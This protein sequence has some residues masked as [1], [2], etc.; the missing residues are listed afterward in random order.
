MKRF[1]IT[2][3]CIWLSAI[4]LHAQELY[5][6]PN[7][8]DE[9][10][11]IAPEDLGWCED[12]VNELLA[13]LEANNTKAFLI[14]KDGKIVVESYMNNFSQ[15]ENWY[16]ASAGKG[17]TAFL[18]GLAQEE[19]S[20]SLDD[21]TSDYLGNGWTS[22]PLERERAVTIWHQLTMTSGIGASG[23][24][25]DIFCTLPE[26]LLSVVEAGS[27]WAYFNPPYTLLDGVIEA[28]TGR[29]MNAF[30]LPRLRRPTGMRGGFLPLG[31]NNVYISDARSMARFGLLM[32]NKGDWAGEVIMQD[33]A[34][35]EAMINTSQ[36]L[37]LSYGY[38]WWLNG[39]ASFM[40]P[41][42]QRVF[43]GALQP[44][45]PVDMYSALG[46]N[47][48]ILSVVP[49]QNIV[50]V[51]MGDSPAEGI[52]PTTLS[53]KIWEFINNFTCEDIPT[54]LEADMS[55]DFDIY[56]NPAK[57]HV[58][59][60]LP[61]PLSHYRIAIFGVS[62]RRFKARVQGTMLDTSELPQGV[63]ILSVNNIEKGT[64]SQKT[65]VVE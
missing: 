11:R 14:L 27:L 23:A 36:G 4:G 1:T 48:Q 54:A 56:P 34:Y 22:A 46:A 6:P 65:F 5:F 16:W 25:D 39:K 33:K 37:N 9:W 51:R 10:E 13:F 64:S 17:I 47:G 2:F 8:S 61:E 20:L 24:N 21:I 42:S 19:G 45:A 43:P 26:C 55:F 57:H 31:F 62:G 58:R 18:I 3:L 15:G 40:L 12:Q 44:N 52:V 35:F 28:A 38:L 49:S 7:D 59:I 30:L 53:D 32:L 60:V 50:V 63:Y 29:D 41:E